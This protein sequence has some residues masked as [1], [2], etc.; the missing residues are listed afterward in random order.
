MHLYLPQGA[1]QQRLDIDLTAVAGGKPVRITGFVNNPGPASTGAVEIRGEALLLEQP[2]IDAI[3]NPKAREVINSLH[4]SGRMNVYIR[5]ERNEPFTGFTRQLRI[6]VI[7]GALNYEHFPYPLSGITGVATAVNDDWK[8]ID[9]V[10]SGSKVVR[11]GGSLIERPAGH[12]LQLQ[13]NGQ[14]IPFDLD[15]QRALPES[16]RMAWEQLRPRGNAGFS[17]LVQRPP[18]VDKPNISVT[19]MPDPETASVRPV[20]FDYQFENLSGEVSYRDGTVVLR[21]LRAEHGPTEFRTQGLCEFRPDGSWEVRLDGV[22]ADRVLPRR[23]LESAI[24][25]TLRK[26][27]EMLQPQG[28][29]SLHDGVLSFSKAAGPAAP[30]LSRWDISIGCLQAQI[31]AGIDISNCH[32]S[33]RLQ[34]ESNPARAYTNGELSLETA[35]V[36][37]VQLTDVTGPFFADESGVWLGRSAAYPGRTATPI[38]AVTYGGA[39]DLSGH[40]SLDGIPYYECGIDCRGIDLERLIIERFAGQRRYP[41]KMDGHVTL[42]GS[43]ASMTT[44]TG[45][46]NLHVHDAN[47]YELPLLVSLL[48]VLR[49]KSP[50]TT[51]FNQSIVQFRMQGQHIYLDKLYF[52]GDAVSLYGSGYTNLDQELKLEFSGSIGR[53]DQRIPFWRNV[54][55]RASQGML[56]MYV[57]GTVSNPQVSTQAF[58]GFLEMIEQIQNDFEVPAATAPRNAGRS[59]PST[60]R[61]QVEQPIRSGP[62][63]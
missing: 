21:R 57:D 45:E 4:A 38:R 46:G 20:F 28:T 22:T 51:A 27:I 5:A 7:D 54:M 2:M 53:N 56:R 44:L 36:Q 59:V 48:K 31:S 3:Q 32:G 25:P 11:C 24:P 47:I 62:A 14:K 52:L 6:E 58:P 13:F 29:F 16:I 34:G 49:N 33:V 43:G 12:E 8:F 15:L 61:F 41:G 10:S 42:R 18:G 55:G 63:I 60:P 39:V 35:T 37:D 40:V 30:V 17:A 1:Q 50:D 23:G 26:T 19:V 9:F